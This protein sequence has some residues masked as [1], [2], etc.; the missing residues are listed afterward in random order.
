MIAYEAEVPEKLMVVG[1]TVREAFLLIVPMAEEWFF[2][3]SANKVLE[4]E[5]SS[6]KLLLKQT[7]S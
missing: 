6:N 4:P 7:G 1:L 2:T 5:Q 3:L